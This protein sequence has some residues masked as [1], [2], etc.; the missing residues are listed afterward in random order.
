L[1]H[2]LSRVPNVLPIILFLSLSSGKPKRDAFH[3]AQ[4]ETRRTH[5]QYRHWGAFCLMGDWR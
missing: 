1:A 5:R 2:E 3:A 4:S